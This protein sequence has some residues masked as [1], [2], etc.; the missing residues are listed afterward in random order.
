MSRGGECL[1]IFTRSLRKYAAAQLLFKT[2]ELHAC[3]IITCGLLSNPYSQLCSILATTYAQCNHASYAHELFAKLPHRSLFL[4]NVMIRMYCQNGR[5]YDA[6]K[7][8]V[9]MLASGQSQPDN[10]TYPFTIKACGDL[11]LID[12]VIVVHGRTLKTSFDL[13]MFVQNNLMAMYMNCGEK[14]AAQLVFDSMQERNAVSWN[15][16]IDGYFR[17]S[18]VDEASMVYNKMKDGDVEPDCATVVSVLPACAYLKN[19]ELEKRDSCI[20]SRE[21][22]LG[23][24]SCEECYV[25]HVC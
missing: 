11:S 20:S 4:W 15:T 19:M 10:F 5:P 8:F 14:E 23:E 17:N 24:Y 1:E 22:T 13:D 21:G 12:V 18:C 16:M 25:G 9:D 7:L 3:I 6:L 2:K